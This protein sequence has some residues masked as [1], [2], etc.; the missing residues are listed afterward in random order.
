MVRAVIHEHIDVLCF[1]FYVFFFLFNQSKLT[2]LLGLIL[3][4]LWVVRTP[5]DPFAPVHFPGDSSGGG[6]NGD[7]NSSWGQPMPPPSGMLVPSQ[8][9]SHL[10]LS[11]F[12]HQSLGTCV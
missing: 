5:S 10:S 9:Y 4:R 11:P 6:G 1:M 12:L 8:A 3:A 7:Y 2:T